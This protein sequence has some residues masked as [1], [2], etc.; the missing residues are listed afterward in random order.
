MKKQKLVFAWALGM[1]GLWATAETVAQSPA[2]AYAR[3]DDATDLALNGDA[4]VED[5]ELRIARAAFLSRG[6]AFRMAPVATKT[7]ST[8]FRFRIAEAG[9]LEDATGESGGDGLVFV[10]QSAGPSALGE[11][12]GELGYGGGT[13]GSGIQPSVAIEFD[14][15][16]NPGVD[17]V[18][19][20]HIGFDT[21]GSVESNAQVPVPFPLDGGQVVHC[22]VDYKANLLEVRVAQD[23]IRPSSPLLTQT[24]NIP[25]LV[26]QM[27][28]AGF[29][30]AGWSA[31]GAHE[32]LH[33]S[34]N[35]DAPPPGAWTVIVHGRTGDD[36]YD[37]LA[38][39]EGWMAQI[40]Q[41]IHGLCPAGA[42]FHVMDAETLE[43]SPGPPYAPDKHHVLAFDWTATS[44]I[45]ATIKKDGH[46]YAA[47]DALYAMLRLSGI[48]GSVHAIIGYSRGAVVV[49]EAVRRM[50]SGSS[51]PRQVTYLDGEGFDT[52]Y[53]DFEFKAWSD[54][55]GAIRYDNIYSTYSNLLGGHVIDGA[56]QLNL[57]DDYAHGDAGL[58]PPIHQYLVDSL[59]H[60]D[61]RFTYS[62]PMLP[63]VSPQAQ[64]GTADPLFNGA[65]HWGGG[66]AGWVTHGG[67]GE[68]SFGSKQFMAWRA[69]GMPAQ[70]HAFAYVPADMT[71]LFVRADVQPSGS[72]VLEL[73]WDDTSIGTLRIGDGA[74]MPTGASLALPEGMAGSVGRL[75]VQL[76]TASR[77]AGLVK[78]DEIDLR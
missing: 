52:L 6:S 42:E 30:A 28:Y 50:V 7:F 5:Q 31:W 37:D 33:W 74:P 68:G 36:S 51:R 76:S 34:F 53:E 18:N 8:Y 73:W 48:Q 20:N 15:Y 77:D 44:N 38:T 56:W 62:R 58:A 27:A 14:T 70:T 1:V 64:L 45:T 21:N 29:T 39:G 63:S 49:S 26:G 13:S 41:T 10:L 67:G 75:S 16:M 55:S 66:G 4:S 69:L 25:G 54:G 11:Y 3:F 35:C 72:A 32:L 59:T 9:G 78:I 23:S 57:E 12:G 47:G 61:G 65:F 17:D 22:W 19:S 2:F 40:G 43:V 71:E 60:C 24:V 46:A